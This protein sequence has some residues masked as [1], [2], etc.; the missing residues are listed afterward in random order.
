MVTTG[1][2]TELE[3]EL[4]FDSEPDPTPTVV[5]TFGFD[6]EAAPETDP[7][8]AP[9]P[10]VASCANAIVLAIVVARIA[11]AAQSLIITRTPLFSAR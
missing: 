2:E 6:W 11:A 5:V 7:A 8:I 3:L 4:E 9:E 10:E 1:L